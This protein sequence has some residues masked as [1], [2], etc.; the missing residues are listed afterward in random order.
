MITEFDKGIPN[1]LYGDETRI[2]QIAVN[3]LTNAVKYT[4][5][6]SV[7]FKVS[8][9]RIAGDSDAIMLK[10]TVKDTGIGIKKEDI[11]KLFVKFERIEENRNKNI[12]GTGLGMSIAQSL[13]NMMGSSLEVDSV[14]GEGSTFGFAVR[15]E[16]IKW[17]PMGDFKEANKKE[18]EGRE[19]Y[20]EKFTAPDAHV[21]VVDDMPMNILVFTSLL[22]QTD[23]QI[24]TAGGGEEGVALTKKNKYDMIFLDHMM[25]NKD[26]I[27]TLHDIRSDHS[28]PNIKT[29]TICLT[30][31]AIAGAREKYI[32]AGFDDYLTKPIEAVKL[33]EMMYNY[34]PKD[35][36]QA[37]SGEKRSRTGS[38]ADELPDFVF[39]IAEID[40]ATGVSWCGNEQLYL[41]ALKTYAESTPKLIYDAKKYWLAGDTKNTVIMIHNIKSASRT[42]G[43]EW[44]RNIAQELETAGSIGD[45]TTIRFK[46]PDLFDRCKALCDRLAPLLG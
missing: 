31:N 44:I 39:S 21:L 45:F 25:P 36:I 16:V 35:K 12:E 34:L 22:A 17:E 30:A 5:E 33:E 11:A 2:K 38:S 8:F 15:Q 42:I 6:G 3:L 4:R 7:T 28:N 9:D 32:E 26:G 23:V 24:D 37:A 19:K 14:Y 18:L 40:A 20:T 43:A 13:L 41:E 1:C 10:I 46:L 29:P 27:E